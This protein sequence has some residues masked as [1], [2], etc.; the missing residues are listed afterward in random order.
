VIAFTVALGLSMAGVS[1][2]F[3]HFLFTHLPL[4]LVAYDHTNPTEL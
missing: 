4:N 2:Y 1:F 3:R